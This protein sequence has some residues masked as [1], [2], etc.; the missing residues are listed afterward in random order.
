MCVITA[1]TC[2]VQKMHLLVK[3]YGIFNCKNVCN[4]RGRAC[5]HGVLAS[6][7]KITVE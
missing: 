5:K 3:Q 6:W 4:V 2:L 7:V 1:G